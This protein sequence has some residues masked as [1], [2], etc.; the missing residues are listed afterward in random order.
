MSDVKVR[1]CLFL[2]KEIADSIK[3]VREIEGQDTNETIKA[4]IEGYIKLKSWGF[5]YNKQP[6]D[7]RIV[8]LVR[9][10]AKV[11]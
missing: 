3:A 1:Y 11:R 9:N 5:K 8:A 7:A 10:I 6:G 4:L 2:D